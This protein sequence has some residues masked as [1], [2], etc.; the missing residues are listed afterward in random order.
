MGK[1]HIGKRAGVN[2]KSADHVV[3]E[4]WSLERVLLYII[5]A[6][7][8]VALF[9]PL[10]VVSDFFFPFVGP[11]S[12]VFMGAVQVLAASYVLL[13]IYHPKYRPKFNILTASVLF[14]LVILVL[15]TLTGISPLRSFWSNHERMT[16]LLMWFHLTAFFV[17]LSS[18]FK[19]H[20]DWR[21]IFIVTTSFAAL[22]GAISL[23]E[24]AG[25]LSLTGARGGSTIGN[26][27]FMGVYLLF[28]AF[29]AIYLFLKSQ[30]RLR[31]Y[32]LTTFLIIIVA[33]FV[34][35]ALASI[36]AFVVGVVL[37]LLLY[38]SFMSAKKYLRIL[39]IAVISISLI[40]S[41][42]MGF[43]LFEQDSIVRQ[44]FIRMDTEARLTAWAV[45]WRGFTERPW[46]GWG[47]ENLSI[48]FMQ[49]FDP[50]LY[51]PEHGGEVWFDRAH[52]IILDTL[53]AS[54]IL[55]LIAYASVFAAAFILL[56]KHFL[57]NKGVFWK[58]GI[59]SVALV[60]YF[61]QNLT[62]FDMI[63]SYLM[64]MLLLS[65]I[66][67]LPLEE[68]LKGAEK[69]RK[70]LA[71]LHFIAV[72]TAFASV[73]YI[74]TVSPWLAGS[75]VARSARPQD[76]TEL[77]HLYSRAIDSSPLGRDKTRL[78]LTEQF[79]FFF[80]TEEGRQADRNAMEKV[81]RFLENELQIN[82]SEYSYDLRAHIDLARFYNVWARL[83][84]SKANRASRA[85]DRAL[86]L[87]P[88]NQM[89]YWV[90][91]ETLVLL[92]ERDEA[93]ESAKKA[94]ELE[95]R[96]LQSHEMLIRVAGAFGDAALAEEKLLE[97]LKINP[98]WEG[99]LRALVPPVQ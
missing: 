47:P 13:I 45:S 39:G 33:L 58:A 17:V 42:V 55:G 74:F 71:T 53:V 52:N 90:L 10:I 12:I 24:I 77:L 84:A 35:D 8:V 1:R 37:L 6:M 32:S 81:F 73:F 41:A 38:L 88:T 64:F 59:F 27:S 65:F 21:D 60:A 56:W 50:R 51:L 25:L 67:S 26:T 15:T 95:P 54:G 66:A 23:L 5:K 82:A 98:D 62:V 29:L 28:N 48:P 3:S 11:K 72:L 44:T 96:L 92:N 4:D 31:Y 89:N 9:A 40:I 19:T 22:V 34:S 20:R 16:G 97:A 85:L 79:T 94:L 43:L 30:S 18:V 75:Y 2:L 68:N 7:A 36:L 93:L 83:D 78:F 76:I 14:Y 57:K 69:P 87:S 49:H 63:N 80:A 91:A 61:I 46:L 86:E 99:H 70:K